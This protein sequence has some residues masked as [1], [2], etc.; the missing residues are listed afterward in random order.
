MAVRRS[1]LL[2]TIIS[3]TLPFGVFLS[4]NSGALNVA[5]NQMRDIQIFRVETGDVRLAVSALG[6]IEADA[7]AELSM[8]SAGRVRE[9][10]VQIGDYV[11]QDD[12]LLILENTPQRITYEQA[13][14]ELERAELQLQDLMMPDENAIRIAEAAVESARGAL[15]SA[16]STVSEADLNAAALSYEQALAAA[17]SLRIERDRVGG[18]AG[19]D[20][21]EYQAANA[22]YG[23][24]QFAAEIARLQLESLR[25]AG[26]PQRNAAFQRL[27]QARIELDR[28]RAGP[29]ELEKD[30]A[31]TAVR[32][33]EVRVEAASVA[34]DR[35]ILRA[36][37]DGIVSSL[38]TEVGALVAP[39][40]NIGELTDISP[41]GLTVLVDEIDIRLVEIGLPVQV[42]LDAIP[43]VQFDATVEDIRPLGV[44]TGGIVSYPVDIALAVD[45]PR[46]RVGMT[47]EATIIAD[48]REDVL[49]IPNQYIRVDRS[50]QQAFVNVLRDDNS[51]D[52]VPVLLGLQG[53]NVSE[54]TDGLE[55]GD[56]VAT[57][58]RGD[59]LSTFVGN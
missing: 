56:L 27:Q 26:A 14:L 57:L 43:D 18:Q 3:L 39:G 51:I 23:E 38:S 37:F 36:P 58:L 1:L 34:Y 2:L 25:S 7:V 46:V 41:F 19:G 42:E 17:E 29:T 11:L 13:L 15:A 44:D 59:G 24:A 10:R 28:V 4:R 20:S 52:E 21:L 16:S 9:L 49:V 6:S 47:A 12:I 22:R 40:L 45:D 33:A 31:T 35:T 32:Q 30:A 5:A 54:V 55:D 50:S 8:R 53:Q 48:Q